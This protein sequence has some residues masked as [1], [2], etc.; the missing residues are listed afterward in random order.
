MPCLLV[1]IKDYGNGC[2][3]L[4]QDKIKIPCCRKEEEYILGGIQ[5]QRIYRNIERQNNHLVNLFA[6]P[7]ATPVHF[8][9][10]VFCKCHD[11]LVYTE[12]YILL[13]MF[14][15]LVLHIAQSLL[16]DGKGKRSRHNYG[17]HIDVYVEQPEEMLHVCGLFTLAES[18]LPCGYKLLYD[19]NNSHKGTQGDNALAHI[20][21]LDSLV[22]TN[23][24]VYHFHRLTIY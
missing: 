5:Q 19:N 14:Y 10:I 2:N 8:F 4:Q 20:I 23:H 18:L 13:I 7:V 17:K 9:D 6:N 22:C 16:N 15:Q 21:Q 11:R 12:V 1:K 24:I 3:Y